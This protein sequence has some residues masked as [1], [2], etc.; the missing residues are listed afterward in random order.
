MARELTNN[1][2]YALAQPNQ[3]SI[4]TMSSKLLDHQLT[5]LWE[6]WQ[7]EQLYGSGYL[8]DEQGLGKTVMVLALISISI[9]KWKRIGPTLIIVPPGLKEQWIEETSKHCL[10][11]KAPWLDG[12]QVFN[13][14]ARGNTVYNVER[15]TRFYQRAKIVLAT[16]TDIS[17]ALGAEARGGNKWHGVLR[18]TKFHRIVI[19][20]AHNSR[21]HATIL[22][23]AITN[24]KAKHKWLLSGTPILNYG[25]ELWPTLQFLGIDRDTVTNFKEFKQ[26]YLGGKTSVED[27]KRKLALLSEKLDP[28][29]IRRLA[30]QHMAGNRL[31]DIE[32]P[33]KIDKA[34]RLGPTERLLYML[35]ENPGMDI[36]QMILDHSKFEV[37]G[38]E[39]IYEPRTHGVAMAQSITQFLS[40]FLPP[41]SLASMAKGMT[42]E[43]LEYL[44]ETIKKERKARDW[45]PILSCFKVIENEQCARC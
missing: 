9:V 1:P 18:M 5:G 22:A 15:A 44:E 26:E 34:I 42:T 21:N 23:K 41:T 30:Q 6:M 12:L 19:D 20:E 36:E 29:I 27:K 3:W 10:T 37:A 16:Y 33:E 39:S 4:P 28:Y 32:P 7:L 43:K 2:D 14:Q 17:K 25:E 45:T 38:N 40:G 8:A 13:G 24:L 35:L 31:I 11:E